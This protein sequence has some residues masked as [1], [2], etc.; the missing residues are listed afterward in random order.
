MFTSISAAHI[1]NYVLQNEMNLRPCPVHAAGSEV[2][3]HLSFIG[4]NE[5]LENRPCSRVKME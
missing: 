5:G 2:L 4:N 3:F 1:C